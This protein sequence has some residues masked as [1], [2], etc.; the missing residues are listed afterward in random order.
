MS[1]EWMVAVGLVL[2]ALHRLTVAV[3]RV[4]NAVHD[5][6]PSSA[7]DDDFDEHLVSA[8]RLKRSSRPTPPPPTDPSLID[9]NGAGVME[10]L[11]RIEDEKRRAARP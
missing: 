6:A 9:D 4:E 10:L 7:P 8:E 2:Y 3:G 11:R 1:W 5:A